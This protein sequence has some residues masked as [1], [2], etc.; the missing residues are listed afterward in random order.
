MGLFRTL[1][2]Q[3]LEKAPLAFSHL[4]K[5]FKQKCK[6]FGSCG[7]NWHWD[8]HQLKQALFEAIPTIIKRKRVILFIDALDE[9]GEDVAVDLI[10]DFKQLTG[11][12]IGSSFQIFFTCR[13]YPVLTPDEQLE[14]QADRCNSRDIKS[15]IDNH[16]HGLSG[17]WK[18][19]LKCLHSILIS[20]ASGIFLLVALTLKRTELVCR[21]GQSPKRIMSEIEKY[22]A[23]LD[24][25]YKMLF[26]DILDN[27]EQH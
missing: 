22:P 20:R 3:L 12:L 4:I 5:T 6:L 19:D 7:D 8:K 24:E 27:G 1:C 15:Y 2:F 25:L 18:T 11:K 26:Q 13:N 17:I 23:D 10:R 16:L 14:I 21:R 9:A